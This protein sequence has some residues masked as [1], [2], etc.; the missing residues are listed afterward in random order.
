MYTREVFMTIGTVELKKNLLNPVESTKDT[1]LSFRIEESMHELLQD[2]SKELETET[3]SD[4]V[5]KILNFYLINAIY[6]AEWEKLHSKDFQKFLEEVA[7]AGDNI[8]LNKFKRLL[9]EFSEYLDFLKSMAERVRHSVI[10]FEEKNE[11]LE[12][13][14]SK[15][16][17]AS[18]LW[19][20]KKYSG[21]T[22]NVK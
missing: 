15:L 5:R 7:E 10:F 19:S 16:E 1:V 12:K 6:E 18:I 13:A 8:E 2:L 11:E 20:G 14:I 4:T 3:V 21:E 9:E 17:N 22:E